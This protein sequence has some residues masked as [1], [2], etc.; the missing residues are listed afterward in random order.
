VDHAE[1]HVNKRQSKWRA[2]PCAG[3]PPSPGYS[4]G[5]RRLGRPDLAPSRTAGGPDEAI[6]A[7]QTT[8]LTSISN[9]EYSR[10]DRTTSRIQ[11]IIVDCADL[12]SV[13]ESISRM[14]AAQ[15]AAKCQAVTGKTNFEVVVY[16]G[17]THLVVVIDGVAPLP[18]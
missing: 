7:N 4:F 8:L 18:S 1:R 12:G 15:P 10:G 9:R 6:F 2:E 13:E 17:A 11:S 16:P 3:L 5:Q 14:F